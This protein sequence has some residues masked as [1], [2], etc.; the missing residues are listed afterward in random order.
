MNDTERSPRG[1]ASLLRNRNF[2]FLWIG[3]TASVAGV[4]VGSVLFDWLISS[5]T[6]TRQAAV[7]LA[8]LGILEF[9]PSFTV[10]VLAG[11]WVDRYDRRRVLLACQL[12]RVGAFAG[13][14]LFVARE[15]FDPIVVLAA[16]LATSA[17]G[18]VFEPA[19]NAVLPAL[20]ESD[21]L[22]HANGLIESAGTVSGFLG[23]PLGGALVLFFGVGVGFLTNSIVYALS[24]IAFGFIVVLRGPAK[25]AGR[26]TSPR[27]SPFSE[28]R[29]GLRFLRSQRALFS[30]AL[31]GMA[32]NFFSYYNIYVVLYARYALHAGP[33]VFGLL[34][35]AGAAGTAAGALLTPRLGV[36]RSPGIWIPLLWGLGG[37]PL[38]VLIAVPVLAI[39]LPSMIVLGILSAVVNVT[40]TSVVQRTVPGE[41]LGR[42]FATES[43]LSYALIPAGLVS[44]ALL[45]VAYGVGPAFLVAGVGMLVVGLVALLR[46]DV[47]E[48]GRA[49]VARSGTEV[50]P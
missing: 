49:P 41:F 25:G 7:L 43:A 20:V 30:L 48:W 31:A 26:T 23:S 32:L 16:A 39:A 1:I 29:A 15:G 38:I 37:V 8:A 34:L 19:S 11:A 24:T 9:L 46:R 10:G 35:G 17:L 47:R 44:G 18:A 40:L 13:L 42:V 6:T 22:T 5:S 12:G 45:V 50:P 14:A 21:E 33:E 28:V 2:R 3:S 4:Y 27:S 36:D